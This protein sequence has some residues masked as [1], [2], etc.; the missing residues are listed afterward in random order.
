MNNLISVLLGSRCVCNFHFCALNKHPFLFINPGAPFIFIWPALNGDYHRAAL[1]Y[2]RGA[3]C[4]VK[5]RC[6]LL[7]EL[8]LQ[9][10]EAL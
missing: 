1:L 3:A 7:G 6:V 2:A 8:C 5:R 4:F 9:M 10:E